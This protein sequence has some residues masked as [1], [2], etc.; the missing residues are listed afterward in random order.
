MSEP[1]LA[2]EDQA[3]FDRLAQWIVARGLETPAVLFLESSR[4]LSFVGSQTMHFLAPFARAIFAGSDYDR[5]ARLLE[6]RENLELFIR[7]IERTA[8]A[9]DARERE[10]RARRKDARKADDA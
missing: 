2:P 1:A 10:E 8:D 6:R 5:F 9:K 4:P 3:L 7:T